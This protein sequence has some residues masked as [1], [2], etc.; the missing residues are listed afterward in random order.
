MGP[1]AQVSVPFGEEQPN[2]GETKKAETMY[3][4]MRSL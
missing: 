1:H 2:R 4:D 3:G